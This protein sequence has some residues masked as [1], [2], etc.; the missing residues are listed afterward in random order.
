MSSSELSS[1]SSQSEMQSSSSSETS[2]QQGSKKEYIDKRKRKMNNKFSSANNKRIHQL[3]K[4]QS[5]NSDL[6]NIIPSST[7]SII[8]SQRKKSIKFNLSS[9]QEVNL[10]DENAF[11]QRINRGRRKSRFSKTDF[12][13]EDVSPFKSLQMRK[14]NS[15][16]LI[17]KRK[18]S[19]GDYPQSILKKSSFERSKSMIESPANIIIDSNPSPKML[20]NRR[21]NQIP[22]LEF[23]MNESNP[24]IFYNFNSPTNQILNR[25]NSQ[26]STAIFPPQ[27][28][29]QNLN[30]K[31]NDY[32]KQPNILK[33]N[34]DLENNFF[35][36]NY[37]QRPQRLSLEN[38]N[39]QIKL[40]LPNN[41]NISDISQQNNSNPSLN[42]FSN[43]NNAHTPQSRNAY[44]LNSLQLNN[45]VQT[46]SSQRNSKNQNQIENINGNIGFSDLA[47]QYTSNSTQAYSNPNLPN[48]ITTQGNHHHRSP[49]QQQIINKKKD[50]QEVLKELVDTQERLRAEEEKNEYL[51]LELKKNQEKNN[52][53]LRQ[54]EILLKKSSF[55]Q[56]VLREMNQKLNNMQNCNK[57]VAIHVPFNQKIMSKINKMYTLIFYET[58]FLSQNALKRQPFFCQNSLQ[59]V[60]NSIYIYNLLVINNLLSFIVAPTIFKQK[61]NAKNIESYFYS[62]YDSSLI[63]QIAF[64][65]FITIL[66]LTIAHLV[67][68]SNMKRQYIR[69]KSKGKD[70]INLFKLVFNSFDFK[71]SKSE[72]QVDYFQEKYSS[73][74]KQYIIKKIKINSADK[75]PKILIFLKY[76]LIF[77]YSGI[78]FSALFVLKIILSLEYSEQIFYQGIVLSFMTIGMC[79]LVSILYSKINDLQCLNLDKNNLKEICK[80]QSVSVLI[81]SCY[82]V[83]STLNII[84]QKQDFSFLASIKTS[85]NF[86]QSDPNSKQH[87]NGFQIE[88]P[89]KIVSYIMIQYFVLL[90]AKILVKNVLR[91][92]KNKLFHIFYQKQSYK[93]SQNFEFYENQHYDC[94][95]FLLIL[96]NQSFFLWSSLFGLLL[97]IVKFLINYA[98]LRN[99]KVLNFSQ[100]QSF[101]IQNR[102][103]QDF[104]YVLIIFIL[105][106]FLLNSLSYQKFFDQNGQ[107][108]GPFQGNQNISSY[109]YENLFTQPLTQQIYQI[110]TWP[111]LLWIL[112]L[113]YLMRQWISNL[114]GSEWKSEKKN[115]GKM[116]KEVNKH[117][118][119]KLQNLEVKIKN[120]KT[121][122]V[123]SQNFQINKNQ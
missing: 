5:H 38:I 119:Q 25:N 82:F 33:N 103:N 123:S 113:S 102:F 77:I 18:I 101:Q 10:G 12:L 39:Q 72:Q 23:I 53:L 114:S 79:E 22:S 60:K 21:H 40:Q 36:D 62:A 98:I 85:F 28:S 70:K 118:Q 3:R 46:P 27:D 99:S 89:E 58:I 105:Y 42:N 59:Y 115:Q 81:L 16:Q 45:S 122:L 110:I 117:Y 31:Q 86:I 67:N 34:N 83:V 17:L 20:Q 91:F 56:S 52:A 73:N 63:S 112:L 30:E 116:M 75:S 84:F 88:C 96:I 109:I 19:D 95:L 41:L 44:Q 78:T 24:Q 8:N 64:Q 35:G 7:T 11:Q 120:T 87:Q 92:S 37:R 15:Q 14:Q 48:I 65:I 100:Y 43:S 57:L 111:P 49:S 66:V 6:L 26:I 106:S 51:S 50:Y 104:T 13:C 107:V 93:K 32:V 68:L 94:L 29:I 61:T 108:C 80:I 74:L 121:I 4:S 71:E 90:N 1:I 47:L 55:K 97:F 9:N 69:V 2:S 76:F 54:Q